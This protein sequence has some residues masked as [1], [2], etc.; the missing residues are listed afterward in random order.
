ME[1]NRIG[2]VTGLAAEAVLLR[3]MG[4]AVAAGG[5]TPAGAY[6]AAARLVAEGALALVSFGLA[7][8]LR[9]EAIPGTLLIP[10]CVIENG[11]TYACDA[12]L[13]AFLGGTTGDII[14]AGEEIAA[15]AREKAIL[16][17]QAPAID[18]ESGA[19]ARAATANNLPFAVLRAIADPHHRN[20]GPAAL[21]PLKPNGGMDLPGILGS[22]LCQPGQIPGLIGLARDASKARAA[23]VARLKTMD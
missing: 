17:V 2:F 7:G 18:L 23:L 21:V 6:A 4:F 22:V 15:T 20:L 8:G 1:R 11:E 12:T 5:G 16:S 9:P 3:G 10:A 14:L 19:V 13:M